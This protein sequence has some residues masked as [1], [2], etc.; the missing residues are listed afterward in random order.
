MAEKIP[1][2]PR[3]QR[4][5]VSTKLDLGPICDLPP[6]NAPESGPQSPD[7]EAPPTATARP[8]AP[9]GR[10]PSGGRPP[11]RPAKAADPLLRRRSVDGSAA[12]DGEDGAGRVV[13]EVA[14][15]VVHDDERR[16][17]LDLDLPDGLHA[18]L[19]VLQD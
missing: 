2:W 4:G 8:S 10:C 18:E 3:G 19:R 6:R 1:E 16:E 7:S 15:L 9:N 17:V 13:E 14:A 12:A 11:G 5:D